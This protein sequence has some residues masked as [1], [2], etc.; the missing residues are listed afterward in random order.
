M[1]CVPLMEAKLPASRVRSMGSTSAA[2]AELTPTGWLPSTARNILS[3]FQGDAIVSE[4][5]KGSIRSD[6]IGHLQVLF[7]GLI[8]G[9]FEW[10]GQLFIEVLDER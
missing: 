6:P 9:A 3:A 8:T 5:P 4:I 10:R 1:I 2:A 7:R